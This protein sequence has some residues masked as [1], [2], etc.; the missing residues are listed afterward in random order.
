M[1]IDVLEGTY[2]DIKTEVL[3][4]G[5]FEDEG[6]TPAAKYIDERLQGLLGRQVQKK[7]L[8]GEFKAT[9]SY[10]VNGKPE[11]VLFVGLGKR[12][13]LTLERLRRAAGVS[14][15]AARQLGANY[16]TNLHLMGL[17][18]PAENAKAVAQATMLATYRFERY[19]TQDLEKRKQL[20]HVVLIDTEKHKAEFARGAE[21]GVIL[22]ESVN[23]ARDFVNTPARD[24]TPKIFAQ[25][26][27]KILKNAGCSVDIWD[28]RAIEK[29]GMG[30]LLAVS[31]GSDEDPQFLIIEYG[32][33]KQKPIVFIGKGVTFDTGGLNIKVPYTNMID[34]KMDMAGGAA[35]V[36]ALHAI[37][38][39]KLPQRV[40]GLVPL[41]EN[42][43]NGKAQKPGDIITSLSGL[44]IEVG[45]TDAEGRLI[46]ADALA[47]AETLQPQA[48]VDAATL[49]GACLAALGYANSGLFTRSQ[50][51]R[52]RILAAAKA[53]GDQVWEL[54]LTDDYVD[55]M[56]SDIADV[57]NI[58]KD[59]CAGATTAAV[60]LEK[61]VQKTPWAHLD[62]AGPAYLVEER[63]Y[64]PKG[65][66]GVMVRLFVELAQRWEHEDA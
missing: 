66:S 58:S 26:A 45:N 16:T 14:A 47:Y 44:T 17:A 5:L 11:T 12:S 50:L 23:I 63:E 51:L 29:K 56:K 18:A 53:S 13:A 10:P 30:A 65:A 31:M 19:K 3:V 41:T 27:K 37:A 25:E 32:P 8:T 60:F 9:K 52:E 55:M 4:L 46:L 43:I 35:V 64:Q 24:L 38:R 34:M 7:Q 28:K 54:P 62:I 15:K 49:T 33:K 61:F 59:S 2:T 20:D 42:A 21:E 36:G 22:A 39:M 48:I 6:L 1:Q 57:R 40:I